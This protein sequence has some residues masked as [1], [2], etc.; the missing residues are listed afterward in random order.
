MKALPTLQPSSLMSIEKFNRGF[1][2]H[3]PLTTNQ[4]S[5]VRCLVLPRG[6]E[7][8]LGC[9]FP[10]CST[11][12]QSGP[13]IRS[14]QARYSQPRLPA[15]RLTDPMTSQAPLPLRHSCELPVLLHFNE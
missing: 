1:A 9:V 13:T 15:N 10:E 2:A 4:C 14:S 11:G 12:S 5:K 6:S 7:R 8:H 3:R